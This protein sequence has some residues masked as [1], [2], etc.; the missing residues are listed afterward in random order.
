MSTNDQARANSELTKR[1][2]E[3]IT[4][5][6]GD[7]QAWAEFVDR[8]GP[9]IL[10]RCRRDG[11]AEADALDV[12]QEVFT[13]LLRCLSRYDPARCF[14]PWLLMI[15]A[16]RVLDFR[17]RK[18]RHPQDYG[19]GDTGVQGVLK[20]LADWRAS[21]AGP[22]ERETEIRAD[23]ELLLRA[24][25]SVGQELL[26]E[27]KGRL[28]EAFRLRHL[29]GAKTGAVA[30]RLGIPVGELYPALSRLLKRVRKAFE[31]LKTRE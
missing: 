7:G 30:A 24:L 29:E 9:L 14:R 12:S 13:E 20:Q 27:G 10:Q 22:E 17:R 15:T 18:G 5:D 21:L 3:K 25:D 26:A 16:R 8:Y 2:L 6:R 23:Y 31:A 19:T 28:W 11:L 4:A 1:V